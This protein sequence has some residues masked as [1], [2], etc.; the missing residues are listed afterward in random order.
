MKRWL[1][2]LS[3]TG[4][5]IIGGSAFVTWAQPPINDDPRRFSNT[6]EWDETLLPYL[7]EN[8]ATPTRIETE[9]YLAGI[10]LPP[11]PT[12]AET[13]AELAPLHEYARVER[14]AV[15]TD[16][17][18]EVYVSNL[19]WGDFVYGNNDKPHTTELLLAAREHILRIVMTLKRDYDRVR[20]SFF[21]STLTTSVEVPGHPAYPSGHASEAY[22]NAFILSHLDQVHRD[23]YESDAAR[24]ARNREIAGVHYPSDSEAG[25]LLAEQFVPLFLA[26]KEGQTLL[27]A[28]REEW[29]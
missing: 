15:Q 25:G 19:R 3:L 20:P 6:Q 7:V 11:P 28:A 26:S 1:I 23:A 21:D 9:E 18:A 14:E 12:P 16:I 8:L 27:S 10:T 13:V 2:G 4:A 17:E 5:L 22:V 24:I 29:E